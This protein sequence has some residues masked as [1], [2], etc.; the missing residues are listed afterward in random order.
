M[1]KSVTPPA[2]DLEYSI[3]A[4]SEWAHPGDEKSLANL[5]RIF[6]AEVRADERKKQEDAWNLLV[7]YWRKHNY[8]LKGGDGGSL[9][10]YCECN[11]C[12]QMQTLTPPISPPEQGTGQ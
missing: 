5:L 3:N 10:G 6:A 2:F 4:L 1:A 8:V 12:K 7:E 9:D 11:L